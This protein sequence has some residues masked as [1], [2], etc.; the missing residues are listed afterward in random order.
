LGYCCQV[1]FINI[2]KARC[3]DTDPTRGDDSKKEWFAHTINRV[4]KP[5][6]V[7]AKKIKVITDWA[8]AEIDSVEVSSNTRMNEILDSVKVQL[9]P[10]L[11]AEQQARFSDFQG[12][13]RSQWKGGRE[14]R[15]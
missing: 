9:T 14:R 3:A 4:I 1:F 2:A 13:A 6:S 10:I 12:K 5:D 11:T 15:K 8:S 7:Q